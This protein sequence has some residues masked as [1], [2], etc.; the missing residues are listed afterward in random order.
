MNDTDMIKYRKENFAVEVCLDNHPVDEGEIVLSVT[1]NGYQWSS[2][3]LLPYEASAVIK[4]LK[5]FMAS[6]CPKGQSLRLP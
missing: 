3:C 2:I 5:K 6:P 1:H 4:A